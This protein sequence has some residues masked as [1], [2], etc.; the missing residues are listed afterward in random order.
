MEEKCY[1]NEYKHVISQIKKKQ[2]SK[3]VSQVL[4]MDENS[5]GS[6][7]TV[8]SLYFDTLYD[9]ALND[10]ISGTPIRE[11][12]R[13]RVYNNNYDYIKLEKKVKEY[14]KGYKNTSYLSVAEVKNIINGN[15]G[16]MKYSDD[17]LLREF[18]IKSK[19]LVI[20][21]KVIIQYERE[22]YTYQMGNTRVTFDFNIQSSSQVHQFFNNSLPMIYTDKK[23]CVLEVKFDQY[24]PDIIKGLV[25][26]NETT[27]S[28]N[29]KY[30][31]GRM[32][33][34]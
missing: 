31:E 22:A 10:K 12:F 6:S 24:L 13:I 11:K 21:P 28:A 18:Y 4:N 16:F 33:Y 20:Q 3:R 19:T 30:L 17:P 34:S 23:K 29:S 14:R 27:S 15:I 26:V 25:Q 32:L 7:Y 5:N 1:R 2:I 8:K 9:S